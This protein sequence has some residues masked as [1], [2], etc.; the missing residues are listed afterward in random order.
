MK[1]KIIFKKKDKKND[2]EQFAHS[3]K[4]RW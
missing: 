1:K 4:G 2:N 3:L